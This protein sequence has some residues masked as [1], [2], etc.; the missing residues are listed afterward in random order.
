MVYQEQTTGTLDTK[1]ENCGRKPVL[2]KQAKEM[3]RQWTEEKNDLTLEE[4][5]T[6]LEKQSVKVS[7]TTIHNALAAM[8]IT[9]K[10]K[11][12]RL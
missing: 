7:I 9:H 11:N 8:K 5:K 6:R 2:T 4:L 10:K 12:S 1:Y 3:I